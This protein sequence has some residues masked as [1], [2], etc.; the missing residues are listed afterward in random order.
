MRVIGC[1]AILLLAIVAVG[2]PSP[3][4]AAAA[5]AVLTVPTQYATIQAAVDAANPG[6]TIKVKPGTYAEQ[7]SIG[8]DLSITGAS[9]G[10]TQVRAPAVLAQGALGKKPSIIEIHSGATARISKLGVSGPGASS[11]GPGSLWAGIKVVQNATL[12]LRN[13]RVTDVHDTPFAPCDHN[14]TAILVGDFIDGESGDA[15]ITDVT[16]SN[17]QEGGVV[18]FGESSDVTLTRS[19]LTGNPQNLGW[20]FGIEWGGGATVKATYNI[21][22]QNKCDVVE[23]PCGSDPETEG[24][25][26]G[27]GNGPGDPGTDSEFA[28]NTIMDNDVGIY[29]FAADGCCSIHDNLLINNRYF[30][31]LVQEGSNTLSRSLIAGGQVGVA[32]FATF[33]SDATATLNS[34]KIVGSSVS[35][36]KEVECCGL[37]ATVVIQ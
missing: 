20:V 6:D 18:V 29:L 15:T 12:D 24:Q 19:N 13:A 36:T 34:V 7:V 1:L 11:C 26:A 5:S 35:K 10:S 14:G 25:G 22:R 28:Y 9:A 32:A 23:I 17:Y 33:F 30:G 27:I 8:K 4:A 31:F 16:I 37:T 2:M 3:S 21:L